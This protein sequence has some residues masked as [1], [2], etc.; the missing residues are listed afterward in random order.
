MTRWEESRRLPRAATEM[1]LS[2]SI[3]IPNASALSS[4][5]REVSQPSPHRHFLRSCCI[6]LRRD[7]KGWCNYTNA[8]SD[9]LEFARLLIIAKLREGVKTGRVIV[10]DTDIVDACSPIICTQAITYY[11]AICCRTS[12]WA[13]KVSW[14]AVLVVLGWIRS[15]SR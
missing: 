2:F 4:K 8:N 12:I 5:P 14:F 13:C 9:F 1:L 7:K 10:M 3:E 11:S 6:Y 15:L